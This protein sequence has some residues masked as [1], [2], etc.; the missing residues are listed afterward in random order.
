MDQDLSPDD[1]AKFF[2]FF[3]E[4]AIIAQL[5]R[6]IFEA[7]LPD[8]ATVAHFSVLNNLI[9]VKDGRTPLE[10]A[11]AFQVPKTTM[12]NTLAGLEKRGLI[13]MRPNSKDGRSKQVWLTDKGYEFRGMAIGLLSRDMDR[14]G[15]KLDL[16]KIK[17]IIPEL[18][19]IRRVIDEDR[20]I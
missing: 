4:V 12:T 14:L 19:E 16:E 15:K 8:G 5:S 13:A 17:A 3:N 7:R 1:Y 2:A 6:S 11:R 20:N 10:L 18:A 9:R